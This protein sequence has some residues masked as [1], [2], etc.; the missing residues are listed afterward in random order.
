MI[1]YLHGMK[2]KLLQLG[3]TQHDY[4]KQGVSFYEQRLRG[5]IPFETDTIEPV[6]LPS[7]STVA[8]VKL[9]EGDNILARLRPEDKLVL[10]DEKGKKFN[11]QGFA[12]FIQKRLKEGLKNLV[13]VIG[14]AYGFSDQVYARA[15]WQ[16]SLSEMTFS[17]QLIRLI[18]MEQ[19]YRAMTILNN[20]PY[21][22]E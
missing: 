12:D 7:G 11:S 3:K 18:F 17:H 20:H 8:Q 21:H 22:H 9:R 4:L 5:F 19:L 13:F 2:I 15:Q 6:R 10:L 1:A 14:G 16:V